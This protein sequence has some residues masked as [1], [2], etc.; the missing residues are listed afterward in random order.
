MN[1]PVLGHTV[2]IGRQWE[3]TVLLIVSRYGGWR[4]GATW[5]GTYIRSSHTIARRIGMIGALLLFVQLGGE[6]LFGSFA[7][8]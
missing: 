7:R 6:G 5:I 1:G 8:G 3:V 4:A 2:L